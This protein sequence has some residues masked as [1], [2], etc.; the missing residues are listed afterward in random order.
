MQVRLPAD[1]IA[2]GG[3][4]YGGSIYDISYPYAGFLGS[5]ADLMRAIEQDK[6]PTC[7]GEDNLKTMQVMLAAYKS[8][9][10]GRPVESSEI[11]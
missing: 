9:K 6:E 5:I 1:P 3:H 2:R 10:E 8:A 4:L 7:R 11:K